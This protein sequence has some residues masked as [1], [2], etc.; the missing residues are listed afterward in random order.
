MPNDTIPLGRYLWTR[1]AQLGI[2]K[3]FGVPGDFNLTLLD[4]IYPVP[5]LSWVGNTNELNAAYAADGYARVK[6]GAGCVVTTHGVGE[7]SALNAIAGAMTEQIKVIHVVGQTSRR[8]QSERMM[9]HH[10]VGFGPDHGV[11]S[12]ASREFRVAAAELQSEE[13]AAEEIDRVLRECFVKSGP[14][15]IFV[16]IDLVDRQVPAKALETPL[17]LE[18][19]FD[20]TTVDEA[21]KAV[22]DAI[23]A[24]KSP[25]LFV[26]CLVNR[27]NATAEARELVDKLGILTYTSNMGKGIIDETNPNYLGLYNG[28]ASAPGVESAFET[29]DVVLTLGNLPSDTNSGG[30]TRKV[31]PEKGIYINTDDVQIFNGKNSFSHTP[32]KYVL[33]SIL[34]QLDPSHLP[35]TSKPT[36]PDPD[37]E[38]DH[39]S[40]LITQSWIW[41]YLAQNFFRPH[42][43]IFGETGTAAFG[44]PDVTFPENVDWFTQTYYGSIGYATPAAFGAEMALVELDGKGE[45]ERGRTL[46][47]T[48]D[49]SIM[50]TIQEVG[51]MIKQNLSP[52]ILLINNA[53]YTIERVIHGAHQ[54]YNDIV[55]FDYSHM[56]PFFNMSP[57]EAKKNFHRCETK[58]QLEEVLKLESVRSP[59]GVQVVEIVMDKLDVPWRLSTQ[60]GTRGPEAVKEMKE[61]GFKVREMKKHEAFWY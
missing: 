11:F 21:A 33:T 23:Y 3:I 7:L 30:F 31:A 40:K 18:P 19:G 37:L 42:D 54:S 39:D 17:D 46:L 58:E 34:K 60:V 56:L 26:D 25:G 52:I 38:D 50:L 4:H 35:K 55:P 59:K 22:L 12:K 36:L 57:S 13:G 43:V 27:R 6:Q 10:S 1:I 47:I 16:P 20:Q 5:N 61:A 24:S 48:G 9:I 29:H 14:V 8:M 32:I 15:Y 2:T 44:I 41:T 51:N 49:G 53:G 45:R 28:L